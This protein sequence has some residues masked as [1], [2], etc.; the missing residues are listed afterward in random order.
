MMLDT[1]L[2]FLEQHRREGTSGPWDRLV[3][4]YTPVLQNWLRRYDDLSPADV[5]DLIQ[6]VLLT[7]SQELPR[8]DHGG[9][10][11]AFRGWLRQILAN[12][13]R[14]FWRS[15]QGQP[16]A[17]GGSDFQRHLDELADDASALSQH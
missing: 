13:L 15:R 14:N 16:R 5:D 10:A 2:S 17:V 6:E 3:R 4:L 1:S 7:V 8:F 11:G 9:Q 12:R